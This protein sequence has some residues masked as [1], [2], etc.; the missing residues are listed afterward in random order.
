MQ[1]DF[2]TSILT[3]ITSEVIEAEW[4]KIT[5]SPPASCNLSLYV[6]AV[7][8]DQCE[9]K[10]LCDATTDCVF[11]PTAYSEFALALKIIDDTAV[12][13]GGA[14]YATAKKSF[15]FFFSGSYF[16]T[17][18]NKGSTFHLVFD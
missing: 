4:T 3:G 18:P 12:A 1:A 14:C 16:G 15:A 8:Y 10:T 2:A 5:W 9:L 7:W 6:S 13:D 17:G 11:D